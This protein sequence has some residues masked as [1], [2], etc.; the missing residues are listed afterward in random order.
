MNA[1]SGYFSHNGEAF[2]HLGEEGRKAG[3]EIALEIQSFSCLSALFH[4]RFQ[5]PSLWGRN[6]RN[7]PAGRQAIPFP[8][9]T[10]FIMKRAIEARPNGFRRAV[11]P[12]VCNEGFSCND[13]FRLNNS[14]YAKRTPLPKWGKPVSFNWC[15]GAW[16]GM[17]VFGN[18]SG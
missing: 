5:T 18:D 13:L 17:Q 9:G 4:S 14:Y 12:L 16:N 2:G 7:L 11:M 10:S 3:N 15:N 6:D 8:S 1:A